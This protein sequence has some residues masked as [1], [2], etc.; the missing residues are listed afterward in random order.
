V[1]AGLDVLRVRLVETAGQATP[2]QLSLAL[3]ETIHPGLIAVLPKPGAA[4]QNPILNAIWLFPA[5]AS[6]NLEQVITE[7]LRQ[8]AAAVWRDWR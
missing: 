3:P 1:A 4:D 2:V 8:S 5:N 7:K 6:P